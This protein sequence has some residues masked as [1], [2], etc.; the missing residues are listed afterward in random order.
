MAEGLRFYTTEAGKAHAGPSLLGDEHPP[1]SPREILEAARRK[2]EA[3]DAARSD[4]GATLF[5]RAIDDGF[6]SLREDARPLAEELRKIAQGDGRNPLE[7]QL[8]A[9]LADLVGDAEVKYGPI[10]EDGVPPG[11]VIKGRTDA[12]SDGSAEARVASKGDVPTTLHE[13]VH[14]AT[15]TRFGELKDAGEHP[16]IAELEALRARAEKA[17]NR[18][19][20]TGEVR[21]GLENTDE[22]LAHGLTSPKFQQFLQRHS[23]AGLWGRFVD[24][25][26]SVLGLE[27]KFG[28]L[29]D[30]TLQAGARLLDTAKGAGDRRPTS[31]LYSRGAAEAGATEPDRE[32]WSRLVD[33]VIDADGIK[34]D[35]ESIRAAVGK[36]LQTVRAFTKPMQR[37]ISAAMFT[38]DA[39]LRALAAK[40]K[41]DALTEYADV[42]HSRA[43][44][45]DATA[46]T[47]H[48]AVARAATTRTQRAFEA[49]DPFLKSPES[50]GRIKD[51]LTHP[52]KTLR[53]TAAERDAATSLRELLKETI[54]YRKAAGEDIGEVSDGY[55]PRVLKVDR[56]IKDRDKFL[57]AAEQLYRGV[58]A[59]DPKLSA[60]AW[61][62]H[63]FDT[64]AGLDGGPAFVR[65]AGGG[66]GG[67][68]S[69][70]REFGKQ[71]DTLL[72]DFYEPDVFHTLASYFTG[73]AKRAEYARRFGVPGKPGSA[74]RDAWMKAHG[75]KS[76]FQVL[77]DRIKADVRNSGLDPEGVLQIMDSVHRSNLGQM[78]SHDPFTRT[79]SSY[80]HTWNQLKNMDRVLITSLSELTMGV[81]RAGPRHGF[82]FVKDSLQEMAR[83]IRKAEPSDAARW[84]E[85]VGVANDAVVNQALISRES[86][87][88]MTAGS[89][90]ILA[91]FYRAIGLHQFTEGE[92]IAATKLG[93][94]MIDIFAGDMRS[95]NP[96]VRRRADLYLRELGVKDTE[97]F[98]KRLREQ[99]FTREE[100]LADKG[101]AADYGTALYR[102]VNQTQIMPSRAE[103]PTWAAHPVGSMV[104]SLM[105]YS[106]G[107]K[108]QVLDRAGRLAWEGVK[109]RDPKLLMPAF[110]LPLMA[111]FQALSDSYLRP[112]LFGSGYDFSKET[113]TEAMIRVA[114]RAGFTGGLSPVV[115]A[116]KA[117]RYDR[118][119]TESLS[120]PL[121]GSLGDAAN[122]FAKVFS[123]KNS[124]NT[125]STERNAAAALYDVDHRAGDRRLRGGAPQGAGALG[126]GAGN[127]QQAGRRPPRGQGRIHRRDGWGEAAVKHHM[128]FVTSPR[129]GLGVAD[130][131]VTVFLAG[132]ATLA[133]LYSANSLVSAPLPNPVTTA[134]NGS[135]DFYVPDGVYDLEAQHSSF[136]SRWETDVE[137]Y[138]LAAIISTAGSGAIVATRGQ[139]AALAM[140]NNAE[141]RLTESG[142]AGNFKFDN[143][144][145]SAKV[146]ADPY[147]GH[148]R[149]AGR[150][151]LRRFR[152][153]GARH[154]GSEISSLVVGSRRP[155]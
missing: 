44:K 122:K 133:T 102:F 142:R 46:R 71:A 25:V 30:R 150:R 82:S 22:F 112:F 137:I 108:K 89:Q 90:K 85:A 2:L 83:Q 16:V 78:G 87:S 84:A 131:T 114:D 45:G 80:L 120:G 115:N 32:G 34:G 152:R 138:D 40:F 70:P 145:L 8:A 123:D 117:V 59:E 69:K 47:Y 31:T 5:R 64:Y 4:K 153:V 136:T 125:N 24:G 72:K 129:T 119:L 151:P 41:S 49:L 53:A 101:P 111:A 77:E 61:F 148:L 58:G 54:D 27:P 86:T 127:G 113:P 10:H 1:A 56:V 11:E 121:V 147:Q 91:N 154:P 128:D 103:K 76:Q 13:A 100:V 79:A 106:Y 68:T 107:F 92:R 155:A 110:A 3:K 29:L 62:D 139:L 143:S 132:T 48:E 94:K 109:T 43:G 36:P 141:V 130:A 67:S 14:V 19:P 74:E 146:T 51:L 17:F 21:F 7:R 28:S 134:S 135:F 42:W 144:N 15:L 60:R 52:N 140:T 93:R 88:A 105:G 126:R 149:G 97:A 57:K 55:F 20:E 66:M 95:P 75:D 96:R 23:A 35:A 37:I 38:N 9:H 124:P 12:F 33:K 18:R 98:A 26:R 6:G 39:R 65:G 118:S 63:V 104:F 99:P 50:L 116:I 73:S 81:I